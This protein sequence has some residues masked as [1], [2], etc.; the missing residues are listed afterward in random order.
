[1]IE[2]GDEFILKTQQV[3][4]SNLPQISVVVCT[5][6]RE[7]LLNEALHSLEQQTLNPSLFEVLIINNNSTDGTQKL[8]EKFA[9][10]HMNFRVIIE[11][12]QGLSHARN[13]GWKEAKGEYIAYMDD[14]AKATPDWCARILQSFTT[15]EPQP[16]IVGGKILPW[17]EVEPPDWFSDE[18]E[19]RSWGE[20]AKFLELPERKFGFS[21]SNMASPKKILKD[22][23]CF[24]TELGMVGNKL[25]FSEEAELFFR[26]RDEDKRYWYDPTI[27][28]WHFTPEKIHEGFL[29]LQTDLYCW[30][31]AV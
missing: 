17:C 23:K 24:S 30:E 3:V 21:G 4:N 12:E 15:V 6:N 26:I 10:R 5:Y 19:I 14:D 7:E 1:M 27:M 13:R 2:S 18:L 31:N 29:L 20:D 9:A 11:K 8:A 22:F 16:S 25:G 28:V